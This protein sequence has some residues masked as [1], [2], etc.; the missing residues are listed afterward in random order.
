MGPNYVIICF[1]SGEHIFE[2]A[3]IVAS[4]PAHLKLSPA[5]MHTF[6]ITPNYFII[7]EHPLTVSVPS[8][9][10]SHLTNKPLISSLRWFPEKQVYMYKNCI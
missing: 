1:P 8:L 6:G 7:V 2:N 4:V 5:Y 9:F 10:K 3:R